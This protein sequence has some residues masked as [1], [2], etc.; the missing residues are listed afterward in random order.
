MAKN[1][2]VQAPPLLTKGFS[3]LHR[4]WYRRSGGRL[5]GSMRGTPAVLLTTIGA[6]TGKE[7]TWP[8]LGLVIGDGDEGR[9]AFA[10]SNGGHDRDPAWYRN[11]R[12]HPEVTVQAGRRTLHGRARDATDEERAEL[13]PRFVAAYSGYADYAQATT[14]RIPVV[15]FEPATGPSAGE[16]TEVGKPTEGEDR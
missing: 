11:L 5:G 10:A 13:W 2:L 1:L 12:A 14:R 3:A 7:R 16:P 6:K 15:V 8:L 4:F 9:Y